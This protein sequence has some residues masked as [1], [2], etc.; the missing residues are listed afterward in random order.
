[1][2]SPSSIITDTDAGADDA[3]EIEHVGVILAEEFLTPLGLSQN[4]A[5]KAMGVPPRR[6]NEII[7]GS[8]GVT[9]DTSLRL[10]RLLGVSDDFFL[11]LQA[12]YD[13]RTRKQAI[14]GE[15]DRI[16]RAA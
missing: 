4:K 10:A 3:L 14:Q 7:H 12:D 16:V 11:N 2:T 5:A 8:R 15:L 1:M 6:I 13:L 9:A